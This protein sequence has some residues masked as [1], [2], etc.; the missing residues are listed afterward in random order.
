MKI[1]GRISDQTSILIFARLR[2]FRKQHSEVN[3][4]KICLEGRGGSKLEKKEKNILEKKFSHPHTNST[5]LTMFHLHGK[6]VTSVFVR[7]RKGDKI[8]Q[9]D[10]F[11][12]LRKSIFRRN[13]R[14][15]SQRRFGS[16]SLPF[17]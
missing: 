5:F 13:I 10:F 12:V 3:R 11:S 9:S 6:K 7:V 4:K 15:E 16:Y 8:T 1:K 2:F 17:S 14:K